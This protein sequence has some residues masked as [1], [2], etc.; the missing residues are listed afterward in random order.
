M[1]EKRVDSSHARRVRTH[2]R[3]VLGLLPPVIHDTRLLAG[4]IDAAV[5]WQP[6]FEGCSGTPQLHDLFTASMW[7][8]LLHLLLLSLA[9]NEM[10]L[11]HRKTGRM[12]LP[13][14]AVI[15]HPCAHILLG[16]CV[17]SASS[18]QLR[19]T[20]ATPR[21]RRACCDTCSTAGTRTRYKS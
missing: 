17:V 7:L 13:T 6:G 16:V 20:W 8:H 12:Y 11:V 3:T 5:G 1:R 19:A 10:G 2:A 15:E 9:S 21:L 4:S 14:R 18:N